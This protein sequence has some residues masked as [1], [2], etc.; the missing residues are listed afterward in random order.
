VVGSMVL[1]DEESVAAAAAAAK[2]GAGGGGH[3]GLVN[4]KA[5]GG[6]M[7]KAAAAAIGGW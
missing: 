3:A 1:S 4:A 6:I 2:Q 5:T 7:T